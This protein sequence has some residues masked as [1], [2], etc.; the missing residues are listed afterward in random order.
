M[1]HLA[2]GSV[3]KRTGAG[4]ISSSRT[5]DTYRHPTAFGLNPVALPR[6]PP[7]PKLKPTEPR[8]HVAEVLEPVAAAPPAPPPKPT[9]KPAPKPVAPPS[10]PPPR[11]TKEEIEE[12]KFRLMRRALGDDDDPFKDVTDED[13]ERYEDRPSDKAKPAPKPAAEPK[14]AAPTIREIFELGVKSGKIKGKTLADLYKDYT[15][16]RNKDGSPNKRTKEGKAWYA[17]NNK[18]K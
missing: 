17:V 2:L 15:G 5:G 7:A 6:P 4:I 1:S 10:V 12:E 3:L 8:K 16:P 14:K 13:W 9:P 11:K 18:I